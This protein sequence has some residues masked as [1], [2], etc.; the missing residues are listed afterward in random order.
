[1]IPLDDPILDTGLVALESRNDHQALVMGESAVAGG[2]I[3]K[4]VREGETPCSAY[5]ADNQELV[6]PTLKGA[7]DVTNAE[8]NETAQSYADS[9]EAEWKG[10]Y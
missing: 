1:M 7:L 2:R 9:V 5:R 6:S 4:G 3:G 10:K 8:S